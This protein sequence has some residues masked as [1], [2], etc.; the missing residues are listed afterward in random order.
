VSTNTWTTAQLSTGR[1]L[2]AGGAAGSKILFAGGYG[3]PTASQTVD[4]FTVH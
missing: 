1:F 4:I 3:G 2:L